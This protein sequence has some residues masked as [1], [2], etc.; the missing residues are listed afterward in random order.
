MV[1]LYTPSRLKQKFP[2][3]NVDGIVLG[4]YGV[5]N[6]GWFDPW[7]LLMSLKAKAMFYGVEYVHADVV[8]FNFKTNMERH[9][10]AISGDLLETCNHVILREPNGNYTQCQ[11]SIGIVCAGYNSSQIATLLGYGQRA[12]VRAMQ[13]PVEPR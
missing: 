1:E 2:F 3:L 5:Q 11:F 10:E 13:F 6:E 12:G 7:A 8:D 9:V 4:S